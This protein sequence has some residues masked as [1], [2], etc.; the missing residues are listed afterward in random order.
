MILSLKRNIQMLK[1]YERYFLLIGYGVPLIM[2]IMYTFI[3][4]KIIY[5]MKLIDPHLYNILDL[6][7]SGVGLKQTIH[8]LYLF[9]TQYSFSL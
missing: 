1:S 5:Y 4:L 6:Q 9:I 7:A 8:I 3:F 2:T